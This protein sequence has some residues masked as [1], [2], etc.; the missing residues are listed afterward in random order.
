MTI[1]F[2]DA[3]SNALKI[4]AE[5]QDAGLQLVL[6]RD[7]IGKIT[8][9]ID[10]RDLQV[11]DDVLGNISSRLLAESGKF[12][13]SSPIILSNTLLDPSMVFD[14]PDLLKLNV[15]ERDSVRVLERGVVGADWK[16]IKDNG[17]AFRLALY[18]FKGG[19][20][21]STATLM[22]AHHL[23]SMNY[24]VLVVDLDLESPGVGSLLQGPEYLPDHGLVDHLVESIID[25]ADGLELVARSSTI[26]TDDIGEVWLAPAG[27]R[28]RTGYDYLSKLNRIYAEVGS[29]GDTA[30][31]R[32]F[33]HRLTAAV[34]ECE[35]QVAALSR[36]PDVVLLDS[37]AGIHDVAAV[38]ITQ[39]SDVSLLFAGNSM[40]TWNGYEILLSQWSALP[41]LAEEIRQRIKMVASMVPAANEAAYI[42]E[43]RDKAQACFARTLYDDVS[44]G[45]SAGYNPDLNDENAPH[46][47]LPILFI[48]DLVGV[49]TAQGTHWMRSDLTAGAYRRFLEG[50]IDLMPAKE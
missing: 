11:T 43:F 37:R 23:A 25:N 20:G 7:L 3:W 27:G 6:V 26:D 34:E 32:G 31:A 10:D 2:D 48:S 24:C 18:G 16:R 49:D 8:L 39:L 19:V 4:A 14:S 1:R 45:S 9:V 12:A 29:I 47:P 15:N 38:A 44:S 28:P 33:S 41:E 5:A 42:E 22:L 17:K 36:P 46:S 21:R 50:V 13:A 40:A 35:R 30:P